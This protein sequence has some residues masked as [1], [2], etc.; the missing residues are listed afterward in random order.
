MQN[1][2]SIKRGR[3]ASPFGTRSG[4]TVVNDTTVWC[5]N[6]IETKPAGETVAA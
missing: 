2:V 6:A 1:V 3:K 4:A 5:Q